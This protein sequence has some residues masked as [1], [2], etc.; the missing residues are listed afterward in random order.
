MQAE[1]HKFDP[2]CLHHNRINMKQFH[3]LTVEELQELRNSLYKRA[4]EQKRELLIDVIC[5][6]TGG[7][8]KTLE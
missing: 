6:Y 4:V 7:N 8:M 2:C 1:G 3:E 5:V